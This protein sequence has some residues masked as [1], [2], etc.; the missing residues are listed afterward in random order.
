MSVLWALMTV[1]WENGVKTQTEGLF[2]AAYITVALATPWM[3]P[4]R[5]V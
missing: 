4:H 3:K 5:P 1:E 2:V